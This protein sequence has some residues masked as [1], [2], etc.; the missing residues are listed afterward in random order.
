MGHSKLGTLLC[1]WKWSNGE[2]EGD[3]VE[4]RGESCQRDVFE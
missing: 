2:E 4:K 1:L 3:Y